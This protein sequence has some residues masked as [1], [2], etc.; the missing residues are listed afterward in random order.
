MKISRLLGFLSIVS[1]LTAT[2]A[3]SSTVYSIDI[4]SGSSPTATGFVGLVGNNGNFVIDQGVTFTMY[5]S[6]GTRDRGPSLERNDLTRDF[7]FPDENVNIGAPVGIEITGLEA[8]LYQASVWSFEGSGA[9]IYPQFIG[10]E[11]DSGS[12][13][14]S[15]ISFDLEHATDPASVFTF[16]YDPLTDGDLRIFA[17]G[18]EGFQCVQ[19]PRARFNALQLAAVPIPAAIWL[20]GS[21]L[22]G[23]FGIA[24]RKKA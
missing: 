5:G 11:T 13:A 3:F 21:G 6:E 19:C 23:L 10:Y 17:Y 7:A 12:S 2:N 18:L 24:R 15:Q 20:F 16:A 8:G 22:I 9:D 1:I 4:N 14:D